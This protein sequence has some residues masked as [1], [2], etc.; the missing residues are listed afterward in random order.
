MV[1]YFWYDTFEFDC[2]WIYLLTI[3]LKYLLNSKHLLVL[4][5]KYDKAISKIKGRVK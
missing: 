4:G 5:V 2:K 1:C 3:A